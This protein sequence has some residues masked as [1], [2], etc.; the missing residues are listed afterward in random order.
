MVATAV[1]AGSVL[2]ACGSTPDPVG[3][4]T[5]TVATTAT[6]ASPTPTATTAP[7][8]PFE[9]RAQ[10][11]VMRRWAALM[12]RAINRRE[13]SLS[14]LAP[15]ATPQGIG[16]F[17]NVYADD[18]AHGYRW[19]GPQPF[20]PTKVTVAGT[21]ASV[22]ACLELSGWSVDRHSGKRVRKRSAS[23]GVFTFVRHGG[24][25]KIDNAAPGAFS[26]AKVK[27]REIR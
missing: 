24:T 12:E 3:T 16:V 4:P 26:C 17:R 8:S 25:W 22:S 2:S 9:S 13:A 20:T 19:P 1:V 14:S 18:L 10:V 23:A 11:E 7:L 27:V 21:A 6:S 15:V 5:P